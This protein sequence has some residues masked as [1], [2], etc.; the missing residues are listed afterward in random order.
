MGISKSSTPNVIIPSGYFDSV[1]LTTVPDDSVIGI[2]VIPDIVKQSQILSAYVELKINSVRNTNIA[3]NFVF[4]AGTI[5][6]SGDDGTTYTDLCWTNGSMLVTPAATSRYGTFSILMSGDVTT[7]LKA[8]IT[9]GFNL[10][11]SFI[12]MRSN[13]NDLVLYDIQTV[14]YIILA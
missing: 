3:E 13:S 5:K 6:T 12:A 7:T 2:H 8:A 4:P 14:L 11:V 9:G 1:T 10:R